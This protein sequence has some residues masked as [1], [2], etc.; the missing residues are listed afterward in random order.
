MSSQKLSDK[1]AKTYKLK[2]LFYLFLILI[3]SIVA[4]WLFYDN[5][6]IIRDF[7][8]QGIT[9]DSW[10]SKTDLI[11]QQKLEMEEAISLLGILVNDDVAE[12]MDPSYI[13]ANL[14]KLAEDKKAEIAQKNQKRADL[15][16]GIFSFSYNFLLL[17]RIHN[18]PLPI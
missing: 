9:L 12:E 15:I 11:E 3:L 18:L 17:V 2:T 16:K 10:K 14:G 6:K 7:N 13:L 4:I 8:A 1:E 5:Q